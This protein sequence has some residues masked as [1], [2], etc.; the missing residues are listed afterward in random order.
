MSPEKY[1]PA[2]QEGSGLLSRVILLFLLVIALAL[3]LALLA[4]RRPDLPVLLIALFA[5]ALIGVTAGFGARIFLRGRGAL[6]RVLAATAAVTLGLG[7]LGYFSAWELGVGPLNFEEKPV[8]WDSLAHLLVG[9]DISWLAL[10]AWRRPTPRAVEP[11]PRP[12]ARRGRTRRPR[13]P[14]ISLP[15]LHF[16][17][18]RRTK[19][20]VGRSGGHA[21]DRRAA[22][23]ARRP[24]VVVG[25]PARANPRRRPSRRKPEVQFSLY[26]EHRCPYC[27]EIVK[28]NDPRGVTECD[29][30]HTLHHADCWAVTGTCQVPHVNH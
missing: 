23:A 3:L 10:L 14:S 7:V 26:A 17:A 2:T 12:A 18:P 20:R 28:R 21:A 8:D 1:R 29:V 11:A 4:R 30:C 27:L 22:S 24:G 15:K 13:L 9:A 19:L 16:P 6:L 5:D 25:R